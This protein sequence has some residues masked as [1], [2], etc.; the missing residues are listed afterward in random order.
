MGRRN[1]CVVALAALPA[2]QTVVLAMI[3]IISPVPI[4]L[5]THAPIGLVGPSGPNVRHRVVRVF[6]RN[7][8]R[9]MVRMHPK[10]TC[11]T[12]L[13]RLKSRV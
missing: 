12:D 8:G 13:Q 4:P 10:V 9:V 3:A 2:S 11:V 6:E 5:V 1:E 7:N